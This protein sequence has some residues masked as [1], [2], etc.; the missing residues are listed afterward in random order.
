MKNKRY[1]QVWI[2]VVILTSSNFVITG[3]IYDDEPMPEITYDYSKDSTILQQPTPAATTS[4]RNV[5]T[6]ISPGWIP[7]SSLEKMWTAIIIHHSATDK[8]NAAI[9]DKWHRERNHW[10]GVGYDFVIGN[11]TDS[12]D[13]QVEVTFRWTQQKAGAH[14]GGT[15]N[16]WANRDG[17]GICLVG[18][19]DKTYPTRS[20][21]QSLARLVRFLQKRYNIP[22]SRIYGHGMT[23]GSRVTE[24]PGKYFPMNGFKSMLY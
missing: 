16:N 2:L 15:P 8:G 5:D 12:A 20:Q 21:M 1:R 23:P 11:G 13:G 22:N 18:N 24:C 7:P 19:F 6:K 17:I 9:F 10:E 4:D 3:C 14:T